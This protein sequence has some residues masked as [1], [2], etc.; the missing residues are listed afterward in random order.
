[1]PQNSRVEREELDVNSGLGV[2]PLA[3]IKGDN[4]YL[5]E[6]KDTRFRIYQCTNPHHKIANISSVAE[7]KPSLLEFA[8][9]LSTGSKPEQELG[10][11]IRETIIAR[12]E[13]AEQRRV[14]AEQAALRLAMWKAAAPVYN[15]R[16]RGKRVDYTELEKDSGTDD[17]EDSRG[18]RRSE[19]NREREVMEY[20]ASGRMVKRPRMGNGA[21]VRESTLKDNEDD[22]SEEE[23]EWSVYSD[24]GEQ[25][26]AVDDEEE[27]D[28][29]AYDLDGRTLVVKLSVSKDRLKTATIVG[30][31]IPVNGMSKSPDTVRKSSVSSL[32]R[33]SPQNSAKPYQQPHPSH[34]PTQFSHYSPA[35]PRHSPSQTVAAAPLPYTGGA[36]PPMA[37][38]PVQLS[39]QPISQQFPRSPAQAY[40]QPLQY[41]S[42]QS[43]PQVHQQPIS[44]QSF[45]QS[46]YSVAQFQQQPSAP[47]PMQISP[48]PYAP[49][50]GSS[51]ASPIAAPRTVPESSV[52]GWSPPRPFG[53]ASEGLG[54]SAFGKPPTPTIT[55][56][57]PPSNVTYT[58]P[59]QADVSPPNPTFAAATFQP[60][61][62]VNGAPQKAEA[63]LQ[64]KQ[65]P[66]TPAV[67]TTMNE[68][69]NGS[70]EK[71]GSMN[72]SSD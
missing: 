51:H 50:N 43:P 28:E 30:D 16:T 66:S 19:R 47:Q 58:A 71:R 39:P 49:A 67:E 29:E 37:S 6:G 41:H 33:H 48:R 52:S 40:P 14:K 5:I 64:P 72:G 2:L 15:T 61:D 57:Q 18:G 54:V 9:K 3:T 7:D 70:T 34:Q 26:D 65:L 59:R 25:T 20:T 55:A 22:E 31:C 35:V 21:E 46:P 1:V 4:Y 45:R 12:I 27:G 10:T 60:I 56:V 38:R 32:A 68:T 69:V 24:K 11:T 17:D 62:A 44:N 42:Y 13:A 23:M 53:V 36:S 8:E 63:P